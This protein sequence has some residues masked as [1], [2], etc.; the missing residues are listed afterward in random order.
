V[1]EA[2]LH[3]PPGPKL[4]ARRQATIA[5][6]ALLAVFAVAFA[7]LY[8]A[9]ITVS[10]ESSY[11]RQAQLIAGGGTTIV[12]VNPFTGKD[13]DYQPRGHYP[14]GTALLMVPFVY[15]GGWS[16]AFWLPM[17]C[18]LLTVLVT[19]RWLVSAGHSPLWA[20]LVLLYPPSIVMGRVAM[21]DAPSMLVAAAGLLLFFRGTDGSRAAFFASGLLAGFS[22]LLREGNALVFLPLFVGAL[23]R[24]DAGLP[25]LVAGGLLGLGIRLASAWL[26]YDDPFFLK[27]PNPFSADSVLMN[28]PLYLGALLVLV[29][30]GLYAGLAYRG[31]RRVEVVATVAIFTLFHFVYGYSAV[32]S[33]L[34]KRLILGPRYFMPLLPL[35][36]LCSADV[37]PRVGARLAARATP[38]RRV[39]LGRLATTAVAA[40][41][42]AT[43]VS[44]VALQWA[45][46]AWA[47]DQARIRDA[48]YRETEE[49]SV[50]ITNW[51][52]T[53]KFFDILYGDR[54]V[55][56]RTG[57]TASHISRL[58]KMNEHVYF[59]FLDRTDSAFGRQDANDSAAFRHQ[60]TRPV[61]LVFDLQVTPT[62][63]LHIWRIR[64]LPPRPSP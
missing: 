16:A 34:S 17:L 2:V 57:M 25:W 6:A 24:R 5:L 35:L 13:D 36:C 62:D 26:Y 59:V 21:S 12:A 23:L 3:E 7:A 15:L 22:I 44:A 40:A 60:I 64:E 49:G 56:R 31:P 33:G 55:L 58:V 20:A 1:T 29:P 47:A 37:W 52:T 53:G 61:R 39:A 30:G 48:I 41:L 19:A 11:L 4:F 27:P 43:A 63:R 8:P 46:A 54:R 50:V 14:L 45:H 10:D 51:R 9:A 32:E 38:E 18:V 28:A 42:V